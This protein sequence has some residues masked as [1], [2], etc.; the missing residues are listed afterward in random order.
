M[1]NEEK[2]KQRIPTLLGVHTLIG[3]LS[4]SGGI[5][6][7]IVEVDFNTAAGFTVVLRLDGF[8]SGEVFL[9]TNGFRAVVFF[10]RTVAGA[11][12]ALDTARVVRMGAGGSA[13]W[14]AV[15]VRAEER[16]ALD[17]LAMVFEE[18]EGRV[19]TLESKGAEDLRSM[20][21]ARW[22]RGRKKDRCRFRET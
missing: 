20:F 14:E 9:F 6:V 13:T 1:A 11:P 7:K 10:A 18:P 21:K 16:V 2:L 5:S 15:F 17:L 3:S 12:A 4:E 8:G 19:Y 22:R